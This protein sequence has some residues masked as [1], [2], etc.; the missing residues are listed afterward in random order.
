MCDIFRKGIGWYNVYLL[1]TQP[2]TDAVRDFMWLF[3]VIF[4]NRNQ[5]SH[6]KVKLYKGYSRKCNIIAWK[7]IIDVVG[8]PPMAQSVYIKIGTKQLFSVSPHCLDQHSI[9]PST[10]ALFSAPEIPGKALTHLCTEWP[11]IQIVWDDSELSL[12]FQHNFKQRPLYP[13]KCPGLRDK[14]FCQ[15]PVS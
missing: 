9:H 12:Q 13:Q 15:P 10:L 14:L 6:I 1:Q 7:P 8:K 3:L 5:G 4:W 11:Y 2:L